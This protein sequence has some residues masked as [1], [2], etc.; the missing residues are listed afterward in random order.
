VICYELIAAIRD[1]W[2]EVAPGTSQDD[3]TRDLATQFATI[4]VI[5]HEVG[6]A[7][8]DLLDIPVVGREEDAADQFAAFYSLLHGTADPLTSALYVLGLW[9]A[10]EDARTLAALGD[11]HA[12][13]LQRMLNLV[14]W[15][16]GSGG[17][18]QP[19]LLAMLPESRRSNCHD[20][21]ERLANS[22]SVLLW[23]YTRSVRRQHK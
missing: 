4:F 13:Q 22:W 10:R 2:V 19:S 7:L 14:C 23:P 8:I 21:F 6:H 3:R 9:G 20:E 5:H 16:H 17:K 1:E 18:L 12:L 15:I 11:E